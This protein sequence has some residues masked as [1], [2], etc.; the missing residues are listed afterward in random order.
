MTVKQKIYCRNV[1]EKTHPLSS[2]DNMGKT[3]DQSRTYLV[4]VSALKIALSSVPWLSSK[5][6]TALEQS[7][8]EKSIT[9]D[10]GPYLTHQSY[11]FFKLK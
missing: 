4:L 1:L 2:Y 5:K 10:R 9:D 3:T 8:N 11:I 6:Y 7:G